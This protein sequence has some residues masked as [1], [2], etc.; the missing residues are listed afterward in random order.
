MCQREQKPRDIETQVTPLTNLKSSYCALERPPLAWVHQ[1]A[2]KSGA[3]SLQ[4][5]P[6]SW[7]SLSLP[8]THS[9]D[10]WGEEGPLSVDTVF[11]GKDHGLPK[12]PC[13][14]LK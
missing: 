2:T 5:S 10:L 14:E 1:Q 11:L 7:S 13:A 6:S 9:T 8:L 3:F 12:T 4:V